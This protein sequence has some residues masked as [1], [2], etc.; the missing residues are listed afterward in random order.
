[1]KKIK[2]ISFNVNGLRAIV[3]KNFEEDFKKI[4]ADFFCLQETKMQ[5]GQLDLEFEGYY[6][7][8][9]YAERKGYSG[10]AIYTKHKPLSVRYGI[11]EEKHDTEGRVITL[12][13]KNFYF[14][15]VYTPNSGSELKRLDYRMD[16][17]NSFKNYLLE[18]N[19]EKGVIICGDLNV[20]HK[21]IDLK[22]PKSNTK[23]A[24]FT[25]EERNKFT[26]LLESGFIAVSYTHLT[27][28]TICS[29]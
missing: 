28:P 23:N 15:T 14:I 10:T 25:I 2:M 8:F 24:G 4:D 7:Y 11:G 16:W 19:K 27:L 6:S 12:E 1:M 5:A 21:E 13:Y 22:N 20:A 18:L 26:L 9:N 3:K 29:V 17:E